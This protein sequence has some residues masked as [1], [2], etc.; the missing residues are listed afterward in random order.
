MM[1]IALN[2]QYVATYNHKMSRVTVLM[3]QI[4]VLLSWV[5]V[6]CISALTVILCSV[7]IQFSTYRSLLH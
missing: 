2:A 7:T 4:L 3:H 6:M 5:K 1:N